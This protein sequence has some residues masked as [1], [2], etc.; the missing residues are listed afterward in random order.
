M[1]RLGYRLLLTLLAFAATFAASTAV[2]VYDRV[3]QTASTLSDRIE[4]HILRDMHDIDVLASSFEGM[5]DISA[6]EFRISVDGFTNGQATV[7]TIMLAMSS[8]TPPSL[9]DG[10]FSLPHNY[11]APHER[12]AFTIRYVEPRTPNNALTLGHPYRSL[13]GSY[14]AESKQPGEV[15]VLQFGELS[16]EFSAHS[17]LSLLARRVI[18][19]APNTSV[20]ASDSVSS[21]NVRGIILAHID[22]DEIVKQELD[23]PWASA[24]IWHKGGKSNRTIIPTGA[25]SVPLNFE[26]LPITGVF[27]AQPT[28]N[29]AEVLFAGLAGT[30]MS[31]IVWAVSTLIANSRRGINTL[32]ERLEIAA[33]GAGVG[34]WEYN[35][36]SDILI[37]DKCTREL[38][39]LEDREQLSAEKWMECL[40]D[41]DQRRVRELFQHAIND[42]RG[43]DTQFKVKTKDGKPRH[44]RISAVAHIDE[45]TRQL[46]LLGASWDVTETAEALE[47]MHDSQRVANLGS[48]SYDLESQTVNWSPQ[49]YRLFGKDPSSE[50]PQFD[51]AMADY[52]DESEQQ[53]RQAV[54]RAVRDGTPYSLNLKTR[55]GSNGVRY[56]RGEGRVRTDASGQITGLYGTAMDITMEVEQE[57]DL[58]NAMEQ[59]EAANVTKSQFLANMSHEIRTPMTAILGYADLLGDDE[60]DDPEQNRDAIQTIRTNANHLLT[61]INDILDVS[62]IEAGQMDVELI[63]TKPK[64]VIDHAVSMMNAKAQAKG[65]ELKTTYETEIPDRIESDPTRLRQIILNVISNAVKFTHEG[66]VTV[67]AAYDP[68]MWQ[69]Q[70]QVE[71]SGVGMSPEQLDVVSRFDAFSQADT[72]MTRKFGGTGLGLCISYALS[73][74]LGGGIRVDSVEGQGSTFTI[75]VGTGDVSELGAVD[76]ESIEKTTAATT[77]HHTTTL[78]G[79]RI[80]LAE[81]G[82]DNQRL[83][84]HHLRKAGADVQIADNG[85]IAIE[86]YQAS[87]RTAAPLQLILMDMQMPELDGYGA[88]KQLRKAGHSLPIIA[89]TAHAMSGDREKCISTGCTDYLTKPINKQDLI[90]RCIANLNEG[91]A[92]IAA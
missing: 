62:K 14:A 11:A 10:V 53:L 42:C 44:I 83:I 50:Q 21:D 46:R 78:D 86:M 29:H 88:T 27:A 48:W 85:K 35:A 54:E 66:T 36:K 26:Q 61:V 18:R 45:R 74:L 40:H 91:G 43:F 24:Q 79:V 58:R 1:R 71:D 25:L 92:S 65:I 4:S 41:D 76:P 89:I 55:N 38:Y 9:Q 73:T 47:G 75:T 16:K 81:D 37:W 31:L 52:D 90:S 8:V 12:P 6:S 77:K 15:Q 82:P 19:Y 70:I 80:L 32:K 28:P 64:E 49:L 13:F 51:S 68:D 59:A 69:L 34:I 3:E 30:T 67:K 39:S 17:E 72:S 87:I 63:A 60:L 57:L 56:V 20:T 5:S 2:H 7:N 84:S 22:L 33:E 23:E